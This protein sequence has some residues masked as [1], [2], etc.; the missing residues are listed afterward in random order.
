MYV[1]YMYIY[2]HKC[3]ACL[4]GAAECGSRA[5]SDQSCHAVGTHTHLRCCAPVQTVSPMRAEQFHKSRSVGVEQI[6][7]QDPKQDQDKTTTLAC[8]MQAENPITHP[9][10]HPSHTLQGTLTW[11]GAGTLMNQSHWLQCLVKV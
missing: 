3:S 2:M 11:H 9:G 1:I 10:R 6:S 7:T 5:G 4:L 8:G